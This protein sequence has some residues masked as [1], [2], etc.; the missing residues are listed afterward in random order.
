[1]STNMYILV[2]PN[3]KKANGYIYV[4]KQR[5]HESAYHMYYTKFILL[6]FTYVYYFLI[7][8]EFGGIAKLKNNWLR[9]CKG[10][11]IANLQM[12]NVEK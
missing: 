8:L 6:Q 10:Y 4:L 1:M 11:K 5:K 2:T 7:S 3:K 9:R 12:Y